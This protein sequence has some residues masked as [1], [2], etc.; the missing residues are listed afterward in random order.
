MGRRNFVKGHDHDRGCAFKNC[1]LIATSS[2]LAYVHDNAFISNGT[3]RTLN[4]FP[5][6]GSSFVNSRP[7]Q[8]DVVEVIAYPFQ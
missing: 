1:Y 2:S 3:N 4:H 5:L 8:T 6:T 7:L